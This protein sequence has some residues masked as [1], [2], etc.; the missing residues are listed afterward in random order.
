MIAVCRYLCVQINN[1][2][3]DKTLELITQVKFA[4]LKKVRINSTSGTQFE[5]NR[6]DLKDTYSQKF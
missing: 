4:E 3:M 5:E 1:L 2:I 6:S